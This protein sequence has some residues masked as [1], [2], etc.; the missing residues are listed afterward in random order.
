MVAKWKLEYFDDP[1]WVEVTGKF[2]QTMEELKG[3][4]QADIILPNTSANRTLVASNQTVKISYDTHE[5]FTGEL[6]ELD[7]TGTQL[8][9]VMYNAVYEKMKAKT[10]TQDFSQGA[11]A[12]TILQAI[13]TAAGVTMGSCPN[14]SL[15]VNFIDAE[16]YMAAVFSQTSSTQISLP[17]VTPST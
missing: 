6:S 9:C 10:I 3:H 12:S 14:A 15:G 7:Y 16:C 1:N 4:E 2:S 11:Q 17:Q 5:V 13:C 8:K